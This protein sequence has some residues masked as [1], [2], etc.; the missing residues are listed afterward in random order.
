MTLGLPLVAGLDTRQLAGVVAHELGHFTQGAGMR[1]TYV[2]RQVDDWLARV[3]F[4]PD[5]WDLRME[6]AARGGNDAVLVVLQAAR[7]GVWL[8][9]R[10]LW[11]FLQLGH[12]ASCFMLRQME[13]D[14]DVCEC[15]VAGSD[16]VR[17]TALRM[18]ELEAAGQWALLALRDSWRS[19][20]LPDSL[21]HFIL[22]TAEEMPADVR[23]EIR[24]GVTQSQTGLFDTHPSDADRIRAAEALGAPGVVRSE[25]PATSLFRD[26]PSL[27]R[28]AT[29][30]SYAKE[31]ALPVRGRNLVDTGKVLRESR[32]LRAA[33]EASVRYLDGVNTFYQ[34]V[35]VGRTTPR[36]LQSDLA[37]LRSARERMAT[38]AAAAR[39]AQ[40]ELD[41][42]E[43]G[44]VQAH[45]ALALLTAGFSVAPAEFGLEA[46][47]PAAA[48]AAVARL[49]ER[50]R[51]CGTA[52]HAYARCAAARLEAALRLSADRSLDARLGDARRLREE[53]ARLVS[54]LAALAGVLPAVCGLG[55][56]VQGLQLLLHNRER[57]RDALRWEGA[58][59]SI[60]G[61]M[62]GL[63][64]AVKGGLRGFSYP[65]PHARGPITL[66]Q[67]VEPDTPAADEPQAV[68]AAA[69]A[70]LEQLPP[71]YHD[72]L[73][74]LAGAATRVEEALASPA[75]ITCS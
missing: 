39:S 54:L 46:A 62:R 42:V 10:L 63:V 26:F 30:F 13:R 1:L 59:R 15:R 58:V 40:E 44:L 43:I 47:T 65:Y 23:Q 49:E 52:L 57:C 12:A 53:T 72:V 24:R 66:G 3:V 38:T 55:R 19:R 2:I 34:P 68:L 45:T 14:A 61:E 17:D 67:L 37:L 71:L 73:D 50:G 11:L 32:S 35:S 22:Q 27:C 25:E 33:R 7:S 36:G 41:Q 70:C 56:R 16:T 21:P 6:A 29:R 28:R 18:R 31:Q 60:A 8:T 9:R 48:E 75:E 64:D 69:L 4:E 74:R 20:R 5:A 51:Q